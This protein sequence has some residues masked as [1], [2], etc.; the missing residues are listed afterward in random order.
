MDLLLNLF[1]R[2]NLIVYSKNPK[3]RY[4]FNNNILLNFPIFN[5]R[6]SLSV[7]LSS[8]KIYSDT[9]IP[10]LYNVNIGHAY[11]KML[12]QYGAKIEVNSKEQQ[13]TVQRI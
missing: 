1:Y 13:L 10:F 11:P 7:V 6:R 8:E 12:L 9:L 4:A 3:S 5:D 2:L